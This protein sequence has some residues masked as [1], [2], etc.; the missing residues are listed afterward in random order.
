MDF[1]LGN[2]E[3]VSNNSEELSKVLLARFGLL[4]RKKDGSAKLHV[5]LLELYERKKEANKTKNPEVAVMP[6][7]VMALDPHRAA[8]DPRQRS[9]E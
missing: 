7:E 6:V 9:D 4:P 5:L 1:Q 8:V 3:A 2:A